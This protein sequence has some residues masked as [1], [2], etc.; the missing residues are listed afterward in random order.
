MIQNSKPKR[1]LIA[2]CVLAEQINL[3][4]GSA[5]NLASTLTPFF[6]EACKH[7]SGRM[8]DADE[9][10]KVVEA[11]YG[12]KIPRLAALGLTDQL[13]K[14]GLLVAQTVGNARAQMS[15]FKYAPSDYIGGV[16]AGSPLTEAE[17][18]AVLNSFVTA[19]RTDDKL[20]HL[21]DAILHSAFFDR[22]LNLDSMRILSRRENTIAAK[23]TSSTLQVKSGLKPLSEEDA[24]EMRLDF[25]VAQFLLD[26]SENDPKRF[27][28]VSDIAFANM[29]AE[30]IACVN[31][32]SNNGE[33]LKKLESTYRFASIT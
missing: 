15:V 26:L 23:R 10:S 31:E 22:L 11:H 5:P 9:F 21:E 17:I 18:E 29:A 28:K 14:A 7:L 1:A 24:I 19:C 33:P 6:A 13:T 3:N 25:M 30:A 27:G 20:T 12:L 2:Y 32:P 16:I 4:K 8:F